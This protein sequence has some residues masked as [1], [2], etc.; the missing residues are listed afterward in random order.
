MEIE[1]EV[2]L[3]HSLFKSIFTEKIKS[4]K[5]QNTGVQVNVSNEPCPK[6]IY[7][8]A[9]PREKLP[10][11]YLKSPSP[12]VWQYEDKL[13]AGNGHMLLETGNHYSREKLIESL[14]Y[15]QLAGE[16]LAMI[17]RGFDWPACNTTTFKDGKFENFV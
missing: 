6:V 1:I 3:A 16:H 13:L 17:N 2:C 7:I 12:R 11:A 14:I 15:I 4:S 8:C 10:Q 5:R 9:L